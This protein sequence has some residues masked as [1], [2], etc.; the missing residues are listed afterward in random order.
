MTGY[1]DANLPEKF[2]HLPRLA[3]PYE[4]TNLLAVMARTVS[5]HQLPGF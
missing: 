4:A 3:K 2:R 5:P 1:A